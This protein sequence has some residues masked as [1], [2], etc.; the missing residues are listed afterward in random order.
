VNKNDYISG[1]E[2]LLSLDV[3]STKELNK[4]SV[5][6]LAQIYDNYKQNAL[7][8]QNRVEF[9]SEH[10]YKLG[11]ST[12]RGENTRLLPRDVAVSEAKAF[13]S[14]TKSSS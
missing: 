7:D 4:L 2:I 14:K 3:S 6:A 1:L 9:A 12:G 8:A 10:A 5:E 13:Y 11:V